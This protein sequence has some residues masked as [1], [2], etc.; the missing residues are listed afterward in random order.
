MRTT[1]DIQLRGRARDARR[2]RASGFARRLTPALMLALTLAC[3]GQGEAPPDPAAR[4]DELIAGSAPALPPPLRSLQFGSDLVAA[5]AAAPALFAQ[6]TQT[7]EQ[8]ATIVA[9]ELSEFG[10]TARAR[11]GGAAPGYLERVELVAPAGHDARAL[12]SKA[13]G[14]PK[15]AAGVPE[16]DYWFDERA[17]LRVT[18]SGAGAST[19]LTY[20]PYLGVT[21]LVAPKGGADSSW[22]PARVLGQP[23]ASV[24]R[25]YP[26][27]TTD[28]EPALRLPP[29]RYNAE[30]TPVQ[31]QADETGVLR[32]LTITLGETGAG[33]TPIDARAAIDAAFPASQVVESEAGALQ[34]WFAPQHRV[35]ATG[36]PQGGSLALELC[37]Y[38][39][40]A[41]L[42]ATE[43]SEDHPLGRP[44]LGANAEQLR[45]Q[46]GERLKF[47]GEAAQLTL[48]ATD[49]GRCSDQAFVRM[50]LTGGRVDQYELRISYAVDPSIAA[51]VRAQLDRI[52]GL[53]P[54]DGADAKADAGADAKA[55]PAKTKKPPKTKPEVK[56]GT[57]RYSRAPLVTLHDSSSLKVLSIEVK[58]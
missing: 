14:A 24:A 21:E 23:L 55:G 46:W 42:L 47:E 28:Q 32:G 44:L 3:D 33:A 51:L 12:A 22:S 54:E 37:S 43:E 18:A 35:R 26:A 36:R 45:E 31:L 39:P 38:W 57:V 52:Y 50:F 13:W 53:T 40:L 8:G 41:D 1:N 10:C 48:D 19:T 5:R 16:V 17:R 7:R 30:R 2:R 58:G 11:F 9:G 20:E 25:R 29:L 15:R 49:Y 56:T 27:W 34:M 4:F 6:S